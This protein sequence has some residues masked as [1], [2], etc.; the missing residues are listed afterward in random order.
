MSSVNT[1]RQ[2]FFTKRKQGPEETNKFIDMV[3]NASMS[4]KID[5]SPNADPD[6]NYNKIHQLLTSIYDTCFPVV[7]VKIKKNRHK[8]NAWMTDT[9]LRCINTKNSKFKLLKKNPMDSP[10]YEVVLNDYK[11]YSNTLKSIIRRQK[12]EY[13]SNFF[14]KYRS[15]MAKTWTKI[16]D[17]IKK[18]NSNNVSD[19]S[20]NCE[21]Y[22]TT[23]AISIANHFNNYY[24]NVGV[25]Y[26]NQVPTVNHASHMDYLNDN[27]ESRFLFK[28][29]NES[30]VD[31]MIMDLQSKDSY[32]HDGISV[33]LLKLIRPHILCAITCIINQCLNTGIF[34]NKLKLAKI[35]PIFKKGSADEVSNYRPISVLTSISKVFEKAIAI[36]ITDYFIHNNFIPPNQYAYRSN[37]STEHASL[38]LVDHLVTMLD[39]DKVPLAIFIDLSRAFDTIQHP[40]LIDKLRYYGLSDLALSLVSDYLTNRYQY[41]CWNQ[42]SSQP[43]EVQI[44]VP[45][46]S[47]LGPLLFLIYMSDFTQASDLFKY[48]LY[49]DDTTLVMDYDQNDEIINIELEKIVYWLRVNKLTVNPA[50][51]KLMTFSYRRNIV[52]PHLLLNNVEIESVNTFNFLGLTIDSE[53]S[54]KQHI[55]KMCKKLTYSN[56]ILSKL[57]N[58]LPVDILRI[59]YFSLFQSHL[60]FGILC[61]GHNI[62]QHNGNNILMK[63]Q[64][65]AIRI[66]TF[67]PYRCHTEPLFKNMSIL[68]LDDIFKLCKLKF[69]FN[70]SHNLVPNYFIYEFRTVRSHDVH[71]YATR[72][73]TIRLPRTTKICTEHCM[74]FYLGNI[75]RDFPRIIT[76]KFVTHS[77]E[78]FKNYVKRFLLESYRELCNVQNCYICRLYGP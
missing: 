15:N 12:K 47:I 36:Q 78:G 3:K 38:E 24:S 44:G 7:K 19:V 76:D 65:R 6:H 10:R 73:N 45:Q 72:H 40:I 31:N 63:L 62:G 77:Y 28:E 60:N 16:N 68:R 34:P 18:D 17:L 67:S 32:G 14:N 46:G 42:T 35:T 66:I 29:V 51:T 70:Y 27:I 55:S 26:S 43:K 23:D 13:F 56:F 49:A 9:L 33:R 39:N 71:H 54:W 30:Q 52:A 41:V 1:R 59:I 37:H 25:T 50:K 74:R 11:T 8:L 69:A 57:K 48:I 5:K 61:W 2:T 4:D 22:V 64:K 21:G 53:L 20:F 58:F 75:Y